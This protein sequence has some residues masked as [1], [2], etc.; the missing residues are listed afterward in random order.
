MNRVMVVG[1]PGSGKSTLAR[2]L[3]AKT[4]LPVHH[5]D[6]IHWKP[7]W[8]ERDRDAKIE[9]AMKVERGPRWIFEGGL[10]AT[11]AHRLSRCDT[12]VVLDLPLSLRVSRVVRRTLRQHGDTR[13]DLPENCPERF[14]LE[15]SH[16]I[17]RTRKTA[18]DRLLRLLQ[19]APAAVAA[20]HLTSPRAVR[21]YLASV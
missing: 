20:H 4:G 2:A 17:W 9:M 1:Q 15:F 11:Y 10:S 19:S 6:Q 13:A 7:G 8:V 16:Y 12:L 3:G 14:N 5:M 18:R 21:A